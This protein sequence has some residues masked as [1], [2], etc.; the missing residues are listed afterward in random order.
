MGL[1]R[2][3]GGVEFELA[4]DAG[5]GDGRRFASST[6]SVSILFAPQSVLQQPRLFELLAP[7]AGSRTL[8]EYRLRIEFGQQRETLNAR[9]SCSTSGTMSSFWTI[10]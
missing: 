1:E 8:I 2:E 5:R 10:A 6:S 4:D 9:L 3:M 7:G